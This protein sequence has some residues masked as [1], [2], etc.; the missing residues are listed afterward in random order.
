MGLERD[1]SKK[2]DI[3]ANVKS[4]YDPTANQHYEGLKSQ[5]KASIIKP[6]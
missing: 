4:F 6:P 3:D 5:A 2:A 1:H